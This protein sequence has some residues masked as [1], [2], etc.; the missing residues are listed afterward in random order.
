MMT[1]PHDERRERDEPRFSAQ[2]SFRSLLLCGALGNPL[3]TAHVTSLIGGEN[4]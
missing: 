3:P 1:Q 4:F 2:D